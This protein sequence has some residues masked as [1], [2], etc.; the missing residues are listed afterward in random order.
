[1]SE[2][3]KIFMSSGG[4]QR[5]EVMHVV[6]IPSSAYSSDSECHKDN[7]EDYFIVDDRE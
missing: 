7:Y 5:T 6:L 3:K 4:T 1:M 2:T